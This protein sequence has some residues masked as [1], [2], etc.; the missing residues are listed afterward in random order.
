[1]ER[2]AVPLAQGFDQ[3][4]SRGKTRKVGAFDTRFT[5]GIARKDERR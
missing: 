2:R 1:M 4:G 3:H 5:E